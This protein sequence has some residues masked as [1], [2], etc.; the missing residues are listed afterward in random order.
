M[1]KQTLSLLTVVFC[2]FSNAQ[3][4]L[5]DKTDSRFVI[6]EK[7]LSASDKKCYAVNCISKSDSLFMESRGVTSLIFIKAFTSN[8]KKKLLKEPSNCLRLDD[9]VLKTVVPKLKADFYINVVDLSPT[10]RIRNINVFDSLVIFEDNNFYLLEGAVEVS[11]YNLRDFEQ[12]HILQSNPTIINTKARIAPSSINE[13]DGSISVN[14]DAIN[15]TG[16]FPKL[17]LT[18]HEG[19]LFSYSLVTIDYNSDDELD[20]AREFVYKKDYGIISFRGKNL[21]YYKRPDKPNDRNRL[22]SSRE[23]YKFQ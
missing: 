18:K 10:S 19:D 2:L 1:K 21:F 13:N 3:S 16:I 14:L 12:L 15:H 9:F 7:V 11:Y 20:Y 23:Y 8:A 6:N 22:Y 17:Y 5:I 4:F